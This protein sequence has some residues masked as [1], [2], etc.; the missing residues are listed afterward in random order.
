MAALAQ[1]GCVTTLDDALDWLR[2][3]VDPTDTERP[4]VVVT[5]DDGTGDLYDIA[6]PIL[7][8]HSIPATVYVATDYIE[9]G[10]PFPANGQPLSW[11]ALAEMMST[12]LVDVGAHTHTHALLDRVTPTDA[13]SEIQQSTQVIEDNLGRPPAHFAYPKA[14]PPSSAI[15]PLVRAAY[16]SAALAGTR[17]NPRGTT[18]V[19]RLARSPVQ[20][21]DGMRWF[22][23]KV[24][25]G[26]TFEDGLR[27]V[28]NRVRY[29]RA[30]K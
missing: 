7:V 17:A 5:F 23:A 16:R 21:G 27:R 19:Y 4:P 11:R 20:Q 24:D 1:L 28:A 6:T 2:A 13:A 22:A 12:G 25:G 18:D 3:P 26:M 14:V 10:I 15:E 8:R 30:T 29:V 9:R